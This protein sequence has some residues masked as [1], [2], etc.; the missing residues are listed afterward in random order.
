MRRHLIRLLLPLCLL[1]VTVACAGDDPDVA[2]APADSTQATETV[3][4]TTDDVAGEAAEETEGTDPQGETID[5]CTLLEAG[6]LEAVLGEPF[7]E[8]EPDETEMGVVTLLSCT[9]SSAADGT[10]LATLSI[11]QESSLTAGQSIEDFHQESKELTS[12]ARDISG[13]GD[14]AYHDPLTGLYVLAEDAVLS[15]NV[16]SGEEATDET[17]VDLAG[18]AIAR[19]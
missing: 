14:D 18:R 11:V 8:G 17:L 12:D 4:E 15:V 5:P 19:L 9:W 13:V 6:D 16:L 2:G 3:A 1:V 10:Q 7:G